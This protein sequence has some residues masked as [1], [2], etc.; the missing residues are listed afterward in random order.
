MMLKKLLI[1]LGL[2]LISFPLVKA[3]INFEKYLNESSF[4]EDVETLRD[5]CSDFSLL[6]RVVCHM[7]KGFEYFLSWK[8]LSY[9]LIGLG[10]IYLNSKLNKLSDKVA[11]RIDLIVRKIK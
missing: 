4:S 1:L 5:E 9:L 8:Y 10:F 6:N 2:L 7:V 11:D 3:D